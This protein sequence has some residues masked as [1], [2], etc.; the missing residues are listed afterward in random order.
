MG[1]DE[2]G[3][4]ADEEDHRLHDEPDGEGDAGAEDEPAQ[5]IA[6]EIVGAEPVDAA[7][8][9]IALRSGSA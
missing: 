8:G 4:D 9:C 3:R 5:D 6:A 1:V 7:S 2:T